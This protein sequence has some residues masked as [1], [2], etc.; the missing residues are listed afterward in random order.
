M[1]EGVFLD[2]VDERPVPYFHTLDEWRT[3]QQARAEEQKALE[4][5]AASGARAERFR[6]AAPEDE[7]AGRLF[8]ELER[9]A[10]VNAVWWAQES[11]PFYAAVLR[12]AVPRMA[13]AE[14]DD[15]KNR[16][17]RIAAT[18]C[19]QL[20]LYEEWDDGQAQIGVRSA[21]RIEKALRW[22]GVTYSYQGKGYEI[23]TKYLLERRRREQGN[24][25]GED[26]ISVP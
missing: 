1:L 15:A 9:M 4:A 18:C 14:D 11:R 24:L 10:L 5:E 13:S 6:A 22:D 12:W 17:A 26:V 2:L 3:L 25:D 16:F 23:V 19:Y 8:E 21:R 7:A 20:G